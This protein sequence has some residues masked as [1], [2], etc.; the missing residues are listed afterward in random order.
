[1]GRVANLFI[2]VE[3]RK[4]MKAV[5]EVVA[6]TDQGL[7]GCVHGRQGSKRQVL[8]VDSETLAEFDLA[9]GVVRENITTVGVNIIELRAGQRLVVGGALL[10]VTIPCE[11]CDRMDE[12]HMGLQEALKNRRGVLCR[13]IEGGRILKGDAIEVSET[14]SVNLNIGEA[15]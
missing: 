3:R 2:A 14:A 7:E 10:E 9:P 4:P 6:L 11:P 13:V 8:L 1:M 5:D 15:R 12:I